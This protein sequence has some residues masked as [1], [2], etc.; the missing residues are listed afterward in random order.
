MPPDLISSGFFWEGFFSRKIAQILGFFLGW[1]GGFGGTRNHNKERCVF[2]SCFA[3]PS[4]HICVVQLGT[5]KKVGKADLTQE[6]KGT[7]PKTNGW[8]LKIS[9]RSCKRKI[10]WTKPPCLGSMLVFASVSSCVKRPLT[11]LGSRCHV[12]PQTVATFEY[13]GWFDGTGGAGGVVNVR[14]TCCTGKWNWNRCLKYFEI[15][16]RNKHIPLKGSWNG[17]FPLRWVGYASSLE[18]I[19]PFHGSGKL[20]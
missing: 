11:F 13:D 18:G 15:P 5:K 20:A 14:L 9:L 10:I 16:S 17:D 12:L 7:S 1:L 2:F 3:A 19:L 8:N 4:T 6:R